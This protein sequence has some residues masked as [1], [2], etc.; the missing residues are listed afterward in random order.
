MIS[1]GRPCD[2]QGNFLPPNAQPEPLHTAS[3]NDWTPYANRNQFETAD[4]LYRRAEMS[5][6]QIDALMDIWAATLIESNPDNPQRKMPPFAGAKHLYDV[7]DNTPLAGTKWSKLS[8]EYSGNQPSSGR[9]PWMDQSFDVWFRDPL[10]CI[11][12]ILANQDFKESFDY[13]PYRESQVDN[14]E[15]R[16]QD[17]MSGD[18]AW[19][20]AVR[21]QVRT[22]LN[23]AP[24]KLLPRIQ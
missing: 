23:S 6:G 2:A 17:F 15:R 1:L 10:A 9:L 14:D 18:W 8:V 22:R 3:D 21:S 16:Y 5:A 20:H 13:V 4:I 7:I 19:L 12:D 24:Y 11:H